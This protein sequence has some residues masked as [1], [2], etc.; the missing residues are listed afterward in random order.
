[1]YEEAWTNIINA[2]HILLVSH[3]NPDGDT[4]GSVLALYDTLKKIK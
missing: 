3:V 2:K 4:L 1:M